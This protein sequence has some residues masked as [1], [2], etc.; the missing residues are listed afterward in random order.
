MRKL[1]G[2]ALVLALAVGVLAVQSAQAQSVTNYPLVTATQAEYAPGDTAVILGYD[3]EPGQE[4]IVLIQRPDGNIRDAAGRNGKADTVVTDSWG[5]FGYDYPQLDLSGFYYVDIIDAATVGHGKN[6]YVGDVLASTVFKDNIVTDLELV[7]QPL[8]TCA[9]NRPPAHGSS[10]PTPSHGHDGLVDAVAGLCLVGTVD[11]RDT[12]PNGSIQGFSFMLSPALLSGLQG[13]GL[14]PFINHLETVDIRPDTADPDVGNSPAD[15]GQGGCAS[16]CFYTTDGNVMIPNDGT[17][18]NMTSQDG[19]NFSVQRIGTSSHGPT[20]EEDYWVTVLS[21]T[22]SA[23]FEY[24]GRIDPDAGDGDNGNDGW[25][26]SSPETGGEEV[27]PINICQIEDQTPPICI[28]TPLGDCAV[29]V[30]VSDPDGG[31]EQIEVL[32]AINVDIVFDN[33]PGEMPGEGDIVDYTPPT[34]DDINIDI[35]KQVCGE[36]GWVEFEITNSVGLTTICDPVDVMLVRAN[37]PTARQ[38]FTLNDREGHLFI[39]NHGLRE[40]FMNLNGN[41]L[42]FVTNRDTGSNT[43]SIPEEGPVSYDIF[44][45]LKAG[46]NVIEIRA[47]GPPVG[48][49]RVVIHD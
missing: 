12:D 49:A 43:Y 20:L 28:V 17:V 38:R 15:D 24:C 33:P 35:D 16:N 5:Q 34:T 42:H 8:A 39:N 25:I 48:T 14:R 19:T 47:V 2:L 41:R 22:P 6:R 10:P 21:D 27:S 11:I 3:F 23:R 37:G 44:E 40:I 31:V 7:G 45:F 32:Q 36:F 29:D 18:F 9:P 30:F 4:L 13:G 26:D 46:D 1:S